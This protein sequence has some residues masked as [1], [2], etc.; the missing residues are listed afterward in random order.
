MRAEEALHAIRFEAAHP[1]VEGALGGAGLA[2]P[3]CALLL[4]IGHAGGQGLD[5]PVDV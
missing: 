5:V 3:I 1:T 4:V 2:S